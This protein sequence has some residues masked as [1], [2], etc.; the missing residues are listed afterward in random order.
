MDVFGKDN[1]FIECKNT[2]PELVQVNKTLVPWAEKFGLHWWSPTTSTT[3]ARR[4]AAP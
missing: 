4:T 3:Y 1:F 2:I